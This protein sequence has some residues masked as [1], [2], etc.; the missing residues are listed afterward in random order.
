MEL[1]FLQL[2][3]IFLLDYSFF[4]HQPHRLH[5]YPCDDLTAF[6]EFIPRMTNAQYLALHSKLSRT[7]RHAASNIISWS[8]DYGKITEKGD[9]GVWEPLFQ[10]R[11]RGQRHP[12]VGA[13]SGE[14]AEGSGADAKI[15]P[16]G[17][18][19]RAKIPV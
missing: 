2:R 16:K 4:P 15:W 5:K 14:G 13:S 19:K 3:C 12:H 17:A 10:R 11:G 18:E 9:D 8:S 1:L 7:A 6:F